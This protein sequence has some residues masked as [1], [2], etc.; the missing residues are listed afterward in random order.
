MISLKN[1]DNL[2]I[3]SITETYGRAPLM[4]YIKPT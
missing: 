3:S 1:L 2:N 4:G